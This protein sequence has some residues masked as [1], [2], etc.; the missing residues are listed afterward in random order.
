MNCDLIL[1]L[2]DSK[3]WQLVLCV[4]VGQMSLA[5][6]ALTRSKSVTI[7]DRHLTAFGAAAALMLVLLL[8]CLPPRLLPAARLLLLYALYHRLLLLLPATWLLLLLPPDTRLLPLTNHRRPPR[9]QAGQVSGE[10]P[11]PQAANVLPH[12]AQLVLA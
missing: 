1:I 10:P 12:A 11:L 6:Q 5:W 4:E 3:Y 7:G 9:A 8:L 2:S